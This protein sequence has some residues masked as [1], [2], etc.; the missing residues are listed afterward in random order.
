M[1]K[2][3]L[4]AVAI[5]A[6]ASFAPASADPGNGCVAAP[7]TAQADGGCTYESTGANTSIAVFTPNEVNVTWVETCTN[8]V[9]GLD[10][11]I[12]QNAFSGAGLDATTQGVY[13]VGGSWAC[14]TGSN[15]PAGEDVTVTVTEDGFDPI[16]GTIGLVAI[17]ETA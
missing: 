14:H 1:R 5:A 4:G 7:I 16:T 2:I 12:V 8:P 15:I 13:T 6:A 9:T 3:I 11:D 10:Y 17:G